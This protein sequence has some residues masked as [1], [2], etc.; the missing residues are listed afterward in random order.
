MLVFKVGLSPFVRREKEEKGKTKKVK[1]KRGGGEI[2]TSI[3]NRLYWHAPV[4]SR[5]LGGAAKILCRALP[6]SRGRQKGPLTCARLTVHSGLLLSNVNCQL[7]KMGKTASIHFTS[8]PAGPRRIRASR[9]VD[10]NGRV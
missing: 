4:R 3:I 5:S 8:I 10:V 7:S 1:N 6:G 2:P 9:N